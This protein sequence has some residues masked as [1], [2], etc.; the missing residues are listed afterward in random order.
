MEESSYN[1]SNVLEFCGLSISNINRY[2]KGKL[3][4]NYSIID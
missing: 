4:L 1:G 3:D 2:G